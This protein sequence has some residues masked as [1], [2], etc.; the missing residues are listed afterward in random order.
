LL[1]VLHIV[2]V[3]RVRGHR[4]LHS[5]P[6]RRS[7]DLMMASGPEEPRILSVPPR[8]PPPPLPVAPPPRAMSNFSDDGKCPP[9]RSMTIVAAPP[10]PST[11]T[12]L[13]LPTDPR[14]DPVP[15]QPGTVMLFPERTIVAVSPLASVT[16]WVAA[17]QVAAVVAAARQA[18]RES[19][20]TTP[21]RTPTPPT[22]RR[23]R[24][25]RARWR[26][27]HGIGCGPSVPSP[28]CCGGLP[29]SGSTPRRVSP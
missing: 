14:T 29:E 20:A 4:H 6:T 27:R 18:R 19:G 22:S 9:E 5:F 26:G 3:Q 15:L 25:W 2:V 13:T 11:F 21:T 16:V 28:G 8:R 10:P 7:S 24:G 23:V 17:S 12:P 1:L